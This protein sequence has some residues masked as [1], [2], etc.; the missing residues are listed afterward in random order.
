MLTK[1]KGDV[2]RP[3]GPSVCCQPSNERLKQVLQ[4]V[5][6][7]KSNLDVSHCIT[8]ACGI[9]TKHVRL[10]HQ[11]LDH[12]TGLR[13]QNL[14]QSQE[15]CYIICCSLR[16]CFFSQKRVGKA[17]LSKSIIF[18]QTN[19]SIHKVSDIINYMILNIM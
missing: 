11:P 15:K 19:E 18:A 17:L 12:F 10:I 1:G 14:V 4:K 3:A 5:D 9:S 7:V 2:D 16:F 8:L 13:L 6:R